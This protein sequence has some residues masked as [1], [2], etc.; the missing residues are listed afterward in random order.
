M[1]I[2]IRIPTSS[3]SILTRTIKLRNVSNTSILILQVIILACWTNSNT[4]IFKT[5]S[6]QNIGV[7]NNKLAQKSLVRTGYVG[8]F[9]FSVY[10]RY[11]CWVE[12]LPSF[13]S[14]VR[15]I[16]TS[17]SFKILMKAFQPGIN[18]GSFFKEGQQIHR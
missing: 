6:M 3:Y 5:L 12:V 13:S 10:F 4:K 14:L 7:F 17:K 8:G 2:F 15:M 16:I 18:K 11:S 1:G 9:V